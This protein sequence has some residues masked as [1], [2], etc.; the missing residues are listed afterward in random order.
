VF[1]RFWRADDARA[2][3]G[4]GLGLAIVADAVARHGGTV[5]MEAAPGGGARA[6]LELP[7]HA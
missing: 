6:V 3:P 5:R 4:S 1:E 2:L 7:G